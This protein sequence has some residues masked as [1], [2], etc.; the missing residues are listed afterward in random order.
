MI[1]IAPIIMDR[2]IAPQLKLWLTAVPKTVVV[3]GRVASVEM[4]NTGS[5][6][7]PTYSS[8]KRKFNSWTVYSFL[9][10]IWVNK[11]ISSNALI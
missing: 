5:Q 11:K 8:M 3:D 10:E 6:S 9:A 7:L 2:I 1:E 4:D